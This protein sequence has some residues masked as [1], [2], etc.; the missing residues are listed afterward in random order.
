[1]ADKKALL[2][3]KE[4]KNNIFINCDIGGAQIDGQGTKMIQ[5]RIYN[6]RKKHPNL[7]MGAIISLFVTILGGVIILL[8]EYGYFVK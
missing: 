1:M 5:T 7:W 2:I 3:T 8:I 4:A 6:F